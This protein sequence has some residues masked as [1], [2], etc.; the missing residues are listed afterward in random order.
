[1]V[2]VMFKPGTVESGPTEDKGGHGRMLGHSCH[3]GLT[4]VIRYK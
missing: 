2:T 3:F 1:M 4:G